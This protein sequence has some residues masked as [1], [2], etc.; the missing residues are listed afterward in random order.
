MKIGI[1]AQRIFRANKHGMDVAALGLIRKLQKT[2]KANNYYLFAAKGPD[3]HCI[4]ESENLQVKIL[5]ALNYAAWEQVSLPAAIHKY[6]PDILHCTA[7]TTPRN[8]KVP[9]VV[10]VHDIIYLQQTDFGGSPYQ[11]LG[12]M[13]RKW[14]VPQAI[15]QAAAVITVS[16][17]EEKIIAGKFPEAAPKI[18]VIANGV[19]EHFHNKYSAEELALVR[20]KYALPQQFILFLGNRAPKKNT[21]NVIRAY[22]HYCESEPDALPIVIVDY[23]R[24]RVQKILSSINK[25]HLIAHFILP[26]YIPTETMPFLY[27]CCAL[28]LYP[29]L[30]ESFGIP[31]LEAMACGA[32]VITADNS[33]MPE[34]AG[35]AA[36]LTEAEKPLSIAK[37]MVKVL[38]DESLRKSLIQKGF[39]RAAQF[40]WSSAAVQLLKIYSGLR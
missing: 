14:I 12:N 1:E 13:Y 18:S 27:N 29:S 28:F 19:D 5:P 33:A 37:D 15:R 17:Y 40:S 4:A 36:L 10:T 39:L 23:P 35:G 16:K 2:D 9:L 21:A 20:D 3:S 31:I 22:V 11:N 24:E 7:N 8:C 30:R 34:T 25:A 38:Q 32:P 26:G 6:H